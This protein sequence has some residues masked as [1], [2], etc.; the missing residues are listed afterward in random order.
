MKRV[1]SHKLIGWVFGFI[2]LTSV[3]SCS[4]D[5][6]FDLNNQNNSEQL[7]NHLKPIRSEEQL[8]ELVNY[9]STTYKVQI[10]DS[11]LIP[12]DSPFFKHILR[13][14]SEN[15]EGPSD[16]V[17][18]ANLENGREEVYLNTQLPGV[19]NSA[20]YN[21][22]VWDAFFGYEHLGGSAT[23]T[24]DVINFEAYGCF[25]IKI[26]WND[27]TIKRL[28]VTIKGYY[29]TSTQQGAITD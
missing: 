10:N 12:Y 5:D 16:V 24:G 2:L 11:I 28:P 22:G 7:F 25:L 4:S 1:F 21:T 27:L 8:K 3:T 14:K 17:V 20:F 15:P 19:T 26:I 23:R 9:L 6:L 29:N 18:Y 13:T